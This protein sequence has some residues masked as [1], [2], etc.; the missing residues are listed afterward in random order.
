[1]LLS[2]QIQLLTIF[3]F[4]LRIIFLIQILRTL[5]ILNNAPTPRGIQK[6]ATQFVSV[7]V[8]SS[9]ILNLLIVKQSGVKYNDISTVFVHK[10]SLLYFHLQ[11]PP[12]DQQAIRFVSSHLLFCCRSPKLLNKQLINSVEPVTRKFKLPFMAP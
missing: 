6:I 10:N 11:Q 3:F 12:Q 2:Q 1:M 5:R 8:L 7:Y 9:K 4:E